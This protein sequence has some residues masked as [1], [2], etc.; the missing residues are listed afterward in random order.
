MKNIHQ[1]IKIISYTKLDSALA[2]SIK[3][4]T[5]SLS[6]F[7][8]SVLVSFPFFPLSFLSLSFSLFNDMSLE[9]NDKNKR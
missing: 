2:F 4:C 7:L 1:N 8:K 9:K 5:V 3:I 6:L